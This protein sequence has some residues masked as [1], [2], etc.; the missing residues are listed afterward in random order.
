MGGVSIESGGRSGRR[1]VDATVSL[2]PFI[3]LLSSLIAF[4][5]MTA[6]WTQVGALP[7]SQE[8]AAPADTA[9]PQ[10]PLL[11]VTLLLTERGYTLSVGPSQEEVPKKAGAFDAEGLLDK[12]RD[13]RRAQP[14]QAHVT[15]SA[16][17]AVEYQDLVR[18]IDLCL[19]ADLA[20]VSVQAAL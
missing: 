11:P 10:Q 12:L 20:D 17:D 8:G 3:D 5:M 1:P 18:A 19:A 14:E 2:V 6:V 13:A 4:L 15:V 16:E 9:A 7:V